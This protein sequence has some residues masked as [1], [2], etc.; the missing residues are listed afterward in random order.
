MWTNKLFFILTVVCIAALGTAQT[1]PS[2]PVPGQGQEDCWSSLE[3]IPDCFPD[4]FRSYI[5]GEIGHVDSSCCHAFLGLNS[6]C[7]PQM[8]VNDPFFPVALIDH[9]SQQ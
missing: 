5:N 9:C 8:F 4:I 6:D 7:V 2:Q 1:L 3:A